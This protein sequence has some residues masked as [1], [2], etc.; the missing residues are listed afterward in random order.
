MRRTPYDKV[1]F[2]RRT[3]ANGERAIIA[4]I[5]CRSCAAWKVDVCKE[6]RPATRKEIDAY[7][8]KMSKLMWN[9][10]EDFVVK[11]KYNEEKGEW[12]EGHAGPLPFEKP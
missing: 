5:P 3:L 6:C 12:E 11:P 4:V 9:L 10:G 1:R 7:W 2:S 8:G